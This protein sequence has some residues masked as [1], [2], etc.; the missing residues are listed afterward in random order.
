MR[1]IG[2]ALRSLTISLDRTAGWIVLPVVFTVI[3]VDVILR[4][5]FNAPLIWG[6]EFSRW[7]LI[8]VF[9]F[10]LPEC[11]RT[12]GHIRME[13]AY[14]AMSDRLRDIV[15]I[16]YCLF[17]ITVFVL[18]GIVEY[19]EMLYAYRLGRA[20]EYL[21]MPLWVFYAVKLFSGATMVAL[22]GLRGLGVMIGRDP[23]PEENRGELSFKD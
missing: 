4:Y 16:F 20:T 23:Y 14:N 11:T 8:G 10:C 13:L 22:F 1:N 2:D 12:N 21:A 5:V 7:M 18:F 15:T 9:F 3:M 17:G 19:E 6:L